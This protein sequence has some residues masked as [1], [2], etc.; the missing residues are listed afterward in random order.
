[1][2]TDLIRFRHLL[3]Q[4]NA[5]VRNVFSELT[6]EMIQE[7]AVYLMHRHRSANGSVQETLVVGLALV[8][9][10]NVIGNVKEMQEQG[11]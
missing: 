2:T 10:C 6:D 7:L 3:D 1:M 11:S 8:G 5:E 9:F 4:A